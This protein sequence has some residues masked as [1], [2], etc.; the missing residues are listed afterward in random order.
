[1]QSAHAIPFTTEKN[2]CGRHYIGAR[3][4]RGFGKAPL[5]PFLSTL[6]CWKT[7]R[8][9]ADNKGMLMNAVGFL[10]PVLQVVENG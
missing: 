1:M 2:G 9:V 3:T 8:S 5:D 6:A 7:A 4:G 10:T